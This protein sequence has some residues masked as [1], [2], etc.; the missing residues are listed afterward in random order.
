MV[1]NGVQAQ[2]RSKGMHEERI[3]SAASVW[4]QICRLARAQVS[5]AVYRACFAGTTGLALEP[6]AL[7]V[8]VPTAT[9][10]EQMERRFGPLLGAWVQRA[11]RRTLALRF[12]VAAPEMESSASPPARKASL[13]RAHATPAVAYDLAPAAV[14][15][16]P[17]FAPTVQMSLPTA[18]LNPRYTFASFIVGDSNRLAFAATQSVAAAPGQS[19][20]PLFLYG[21][22]GLGKTHLLMALGHVAATLGLRVQY[23]TSETFTNEIVMAIQKNA[24]DAF[25]ALY[26]TIDVLLVDDI[27]FIGGKERTEEEFFHTFNALHNANKQIVVTSDRPPRAIPTLHDR[28]RSRFEWGLL[29]DI[30]APDYAHRLAI[31]TA[32]AASLDLPVPAAALDYIAR[33]E[34]SSVRQL[35]GA[36][37]RLVVTARMRGS[38]ITLA[39][40]AQ[41]L[42]ECFGDRGRIA[43]SPQVVIDLVAAHYHIEVAA[44]LGKGRMRTVA[45]PRQVAMYLLREET[46]QS[47]AQIGAALGGRDHTTIMHGCDQV[48]ETLRHDEHL[49]R[50]I[51]TLRA[52]LRSL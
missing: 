31:L 5:P 34:G 46:E 36:L 25:R 10:R 6:D 43:I 12:T 48:A 29:A 4:R 38:A 39:L 45:W 15:P 52:M 50:E 8:A 40:T 20:N 42:R 35:E 19:Y 23:V 1:G 26:R 13:P 17:V 51:E 22:V 27:Q 33:P 11:A 7:V 24:Q 32:K 30:T 14:H 47:L 3:A 28:L 44:I 18:N 21:G 49:Q 37:N 41:T 16:A 9:V 2:G